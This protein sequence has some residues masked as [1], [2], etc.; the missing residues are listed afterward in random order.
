MV[1]E[2]ARGGWLPAAAGGWLGAAAGTG[3]GSAGDESAGDE[4]VGGAMPI[5]VPLKLLGRAGAGAAGAGA[6]GSEGFST[7]VPPSA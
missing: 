4:N 7:S 5:I 3:A 6:G 2:K 1:P